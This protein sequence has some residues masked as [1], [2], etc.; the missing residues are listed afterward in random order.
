MAKKC[1]G[2]LNVFFYILPREY[3]DLIHF[4]M[5]G[6]LQPQSSTGCNSGTSM[7]RPLLVDPNM[8]GIRI[9]YPQELSVVR[10][11]QTHRSYSEVYISKPVEY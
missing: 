2:G 3:F 7:L 8:S 4:F 9:I 10:Q 11:L 1:V 6:V 5:L